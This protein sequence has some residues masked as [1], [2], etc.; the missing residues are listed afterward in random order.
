M[1]D[2][3]HYRCECAIGWT[4]NK[5]QLRDNCAS[6][7]CKN[8]AKCVTTDGGFVC[9]CANG[10]K[11]ALCTQDVDECSEGIQNNNNNN[12]LALHS[13]SHSHSHSICS[14][15]GF[16]VNTMGGYRCN[17]DKGFTGMNCETRWASLTT[18]ILVILYL[19]I[20]LHYR[21]RV[22]PIRV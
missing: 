5:C 13:N 22:K 9:E 7:P 14:S 21:F 20:A 10:F 2:L 8:G 1:N 3:Q 17:C 19:H 11:G 12:S 6:S 4:G 15:R 18:L 16:C